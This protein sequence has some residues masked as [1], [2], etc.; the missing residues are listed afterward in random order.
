MSLAIAIKKGDTIFVGADSL[1]SQKYGLTSILK[2]GHE[3]TWE[4]KESGVI[5]AHTGLLVDRNIIEM[6]DDII[7][8]AFTDKTIR[9]KDV[10]NNIVPKMMSL[11]EKRKKSENDKCSCSS[12]IFAHRDK[13]YEIGAE[14]CVVEPYD[15]YISVGS[16]SE[17]ADGAFQV[18][19]DYEHFT[20]EQKIVKIILA[21]CAIHS[22][23][24]YPIRIINTK[25]DDVVFICNEEEADKVCKLGVQ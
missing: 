21:A 23:V 25:N 3:K 5:F 15:D 11:L 22:S 6:S 16:G 9:F 13:L 4:V 20:P 24:G 7:D 17:V 8:K 19:K 14:G 1:M 10:V 2:E 18:I 12:F